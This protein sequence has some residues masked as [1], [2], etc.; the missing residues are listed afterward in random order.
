MFIPPDRPKIAGAKKDSK[1]IVIGGNVYRIVETETGKSQVFEYVRIEI[2]L[3]ESK[4]LRRK[5]YGHNL[6]GLYDIDFYPTIEKPPEM[7]KL[8]MEGRFIL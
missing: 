2:V 1:F 8:N 3:S 5:F 7:K 4:H 6:A